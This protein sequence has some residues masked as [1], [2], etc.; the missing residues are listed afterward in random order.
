MPIKRKFSAFWTATMLGLVLFLL[1]AA[2]NPCDNFPCSDDKYCTINEC[3]WHGGD[4][5]ECV[6]RNRSC[7]DNYF[8]TND[9][10]DEDLNECAHE[11][12]ECPNPGNP[13]LLG[14]FCV[15]ETGCTEFLKDCDDENECTDDLCDQKTGE[16]YHVRIYDKPQCAS[17]T[18][19]AFAVSVNVFC[20]LFFSIFVQ[21]V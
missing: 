19:D 14:V 8:C 20:V 17:I 2:E 9:W 6:S 18:A 7:E 3:I 21:N 16:C 11:Y 5:Y 13:C 1:A 10:C 12:I 4:N 15:E